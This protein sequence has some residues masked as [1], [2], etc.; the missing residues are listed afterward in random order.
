MPLL[1]FQTRKKL[2]A[3]AHRWHYR[4]LWLSAIAV[5]VWGCS[6]ALHPVMG[7]IG[8]SPAT[9]LPPPVV[10][11]HMATMRLPTILQQLGN[12]AI[13]RIRWVKLQQG[14]AIQISEDKQLQRRYFLAGDG[15][16]LPYYSD[17]VYAASLA[18]HFTG[19]INDG[20]RDITLITAFSDEYPWVNRQLPVYRVAFADRQNTTAFIHTGTST[21]AALSNDRKETIQTLF[22]KLHTLNFLDDYEW[23]RI[24]V[25]LLF[26][27][28][29]GFSALTGL[30]MILLIKRKPQQTSR[31]WHRKLAVICCVPLLCFSIS[32]IHHLL[33]MS[34][35][36]L[37]RGQSSI[38]PV[39][40]PEGFSA[41]AAM[42]AL[43]TLPSTRWRDISLV[44][45]DAQLLLRL[46]EMPAAASTPPN[47]AKKPAAMDE[48][49]H[50]DGGREQRFKGM[51]QEGAIRYIDLLSGKPANWLDEQQA[52]RIAR[53]TMNIADSDIASI[54]RLTHFSA[55]YDFRNK[56][57]PVWELQLTNQPAKLAYIDT[58]GNRVIEV[59]GASEIAEVWNF[60]L[61]HKWNFLVFPIGR[62]ARDALV[63]AVIA[64]CV[65]LTATGMVLRLAKRS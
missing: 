51:P 19:K 43:H 45:N 54:K 60:S 64:L 53:Q 21:L 18:R 14:L 26:V 62:E 36:S 23:L 32:G 12:T 11:D 48:H 65:L 7:K 20:V 47:S 5:F 56:R 30:Q 37:L 34:G 33:Q 10:I 13:E 61:L 49:A 3:I 6:G 52:R 31:W 63:L 57:L 41:D 59:L 16:E 25:A 29:L 39:R 9:M 1:N 42:H 22:G 38:S 17:E 50:H 24:P 27:G 46:A 44:Q 8:P 55:T 35:G 58:A 40:L 15:S 28:A 2:Q 4:L